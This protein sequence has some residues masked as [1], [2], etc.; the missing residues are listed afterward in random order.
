MEKLQ[1]YTER[2]SVPPQP[3]SLWYHDQN[4]EINIGT[5]LWTKLKTSFKCHQFFH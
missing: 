3:G 2:A 4:Q 5:M 1:Q